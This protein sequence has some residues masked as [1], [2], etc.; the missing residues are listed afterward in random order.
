MR[1][2]LVCPYLPW[3]TNSGGRIRIAAFA[4]ALAGLGELWLFA[5]GTVRELGEG[6]ASPEFRLFRGRQVATDPLAPLGLLEGTVR[7]RRS[8]PA[9]LGR[10]LAEAH[11]RAPFDLVVVEHAHAAGPARSLK[12]VPLL[13]DEHNV[14][15]RYWRER[16]AAAGRLRERLERREVEA[17]R[18]WEQTLWALAD[19][20]TCVCDEDAHE[21]GRHRARPA[22]VVPNGVALDRVPFR[23]PS[24]RAGFDVLFVGMMAFPPNAAAAVELATSIM[25]RVWAQEPRA[26]LVLCGRDPPREVRRLESYRVEV[27]GTVPS[28]APYLDGAAVYANALRRGAGS[29]LKTVEAL[30]SGLPLVSTEVGVRGFPLSPREHY[31]LADDAPSFAAA[32]VACLADRRARDPAAYAARTVAERYDWAQLAGE[33]ARLARAT[34]EAPRGLPFRS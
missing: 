18:R 31:L 13:L 15:S 1:T 16:A 9:A 3:P 24:E 34:A 2:A 21:I 32:L 22:R 10:A 14:E 6:E 5:K 33:F 25:P 30:A 28:V 17:L 23:P 29:S 7:L 12:G 26:R 19:E 8:G 4:R 20:V 27:T 11:A